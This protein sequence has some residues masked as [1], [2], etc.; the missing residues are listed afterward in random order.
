MGASKTFETLFPGARR[1]LLSALF[2]EPHRWWTIEELAG[3]AGVRPG[4]IQPQLVRLREGGVVREER[5]GGR[6]KFQPNAECQIFAEL[7]AIVMKLTSGSG[8]ETILVV[9]DTAATAQ[10]TRILL[11]SWGY[12]VIEAH[13][14]AEALDVFDAQGKEIQL[15]LTDVMMPQMTGPQLADEF[16][17]RNPQVRVVYMSG[18]PDQELD[19]LDEM[20]LAK[21]FNPAGLSQMV[22]KALDTSVAGTAG[23]GKRINGR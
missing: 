15:V 13:S 16:R 1:T 12:R 8:G 11:E 9:E 6:A 14:P 19:R 17:R 4:S 21:P 3:R 2:G 23:C 18:Y 22:R 5:A 10:I 7:Q 20:F